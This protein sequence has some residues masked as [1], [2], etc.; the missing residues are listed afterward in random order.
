MA[1]YRQRSM[2]THIVRREW[3]LQV[4]QI[5]AAL[6]NHIQF[7]MGQACEAERVFHRGPIAVDNRD[8]LIIQRAMVQ[9]LDDD[10]CANASGI[11]HC[12]TNQLFHNKAPP[13]VF[14]K[15]FLSDSQFIRYFNKNQPCF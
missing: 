13:F 1:L 4:E 8:G 15:L 6:L 9:C 5:F 12:N 14:T 7:Q 11:A 2:L 10:L 3:I